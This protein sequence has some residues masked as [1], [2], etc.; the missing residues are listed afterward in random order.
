MYKQLSIDNYNKT[1][2]ML[3]DK[4]KD[5]Y[6]LMYF[7]FIF[8]CTIYKLYTVRLKCLLSRCMHKQC[9]IDKLCLT[10]CIYPV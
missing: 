6:K 3:I 5:D 2:H 7:I 4:Y 8:T 10:E 1:W 9:H